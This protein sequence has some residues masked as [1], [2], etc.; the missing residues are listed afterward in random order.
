MGFYAHRRVAVAVTLSACG[1]LS[2]GSLAQVIPQSRSFTK[3]WRNAG[4]PGDIPAPARIV[5]VR[6]Y[7]AQGNG[8]NND[9]PA[10]NNAIAALGTTGGVVYLLYRSSS[11]GG[12][13]ISE[14]KKS[15]AEEEH[16]IE[17]NA[18]RGRGIDG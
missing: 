3:S 12:P 17:E 4:Y 13:K 2:T 1:I 8:T 16:I 6:D 11:P 5:N 14:M 15:V 10:I 7:G 18:E 9:A